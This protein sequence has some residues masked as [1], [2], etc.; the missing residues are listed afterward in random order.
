MAMKQTEAQG[1]PQAMER[2]RER[3]RN[4]NQEMAESLARIAGIRTEDVIGM[5]R[6]GMGWGQIAQEL[7]LEPEHLG[8]DKQRSQTTTPDKLKVQDRTG[9]RDRD[10]DFSQQV[11]FEPKR[12]RE[13][14][15]E[16]SEATSRNLQNAGATKHGMAM[17]G[18]GSKGMGLA[19]A[20]HAMFTGISQASVGSSGITAGAG[21]SGSDGGNGGCGGS[22]GG[23]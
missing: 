18:A 4:A 22:E 1:N 21:E 23:P 2:A 11:S 19:K 20:K 8:I 5:Q 12:T 16:F 10:R 7:G 14:N 6:A 9:D 17:V 3:H 15:K 13:R